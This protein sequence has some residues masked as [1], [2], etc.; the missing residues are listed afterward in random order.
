MTDD[1]STV[2]A[3][4]ERVRTAVVDPLTEFLHD[5]AAGGIALAIATVVALVW[6]NSTF[7][8]E[9]LSLW[10]TKL[11][12]GIGAAVISEDLRHWVNDG[13]MAMFFFIVG[14]EIKR[15]LVCGELQ[16]RRSAALP[17]MAA[18]GGVAV[19]A[20]IFTAITLGTDS[21]DGWA[22]PAATDIAFAIGVL[23]LLG[24]RISPGLK[25]FLLTIAIVDDIVAIV[26]IA[27]FYSKGL[28]LGWLAIA[29]AALLS[30]LVLQRLGATRPWHYIP[31]ALV[32]WVA[33]HESGV[34]AT[35]AGVAL[36]LLTPTG[37]IAGRR[38]LEDL[39]HRLH[40]ISAFAIVPLFAL[41][42]AGVDLGGGAIGDAASSRLAWAIVA[43]LVLGKLIGIAGATFLGLRLGWGT[44]PDQVTK[45]QVWGVAALGGIGFTVSLFIA[46][47]AYDDAA[48]VDTAKIGILAG[49]ILSG[50]VGIAIL[51][52]RTPVPDAPPEP[53]AQPAPA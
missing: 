15:E 23:A 52:R 5:E 1:Q 16:D 6:A 20:L 7:S 22:I 19:P 30:V 44:L 4:A 18:A 17:I 42:N 40:P 34:H 45:A 37:K 13:L 27:V 29:V 31:I 28:A 12:L 35:I 39:E 25:L 51:R 41:A 53:D 26:I 50:L 38:V 11:T 36:G 2:A 21:I 8:D 14:L 32:A 9:Y 33:T 24:D 47:L 3:A 46:D 43:G 49:S 10:D 48:L